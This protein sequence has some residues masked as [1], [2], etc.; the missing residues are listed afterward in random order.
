VRTYNRSHRT[1]CKEK[2][3]DAYKSIP[4][5]PMYS[6]SECNSPLK[7]WPVEKIEKSQCLKCRNFEIINSGSN[8]HMC[9]VCDSVLCDRHNAFFPITG[10]RMVVDFGKMDT[11]VTMEQGNSSIR[12]PLLGAQ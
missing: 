7:L 2:L 3:Q 9:F 6:C 5:S 11:L 12:Q 8:L 1:D 4:D 10:G